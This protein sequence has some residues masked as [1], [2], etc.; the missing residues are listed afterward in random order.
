MKH[1]FGGFFG[2]S[3]FC[4]QLP[5]CLL[6]LEKLHN[7][8]E[9]WHM[10]DSTKERMNLYKCLQV[11]DVLRSLALAVVILLILLLGVACQVM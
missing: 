7:C 1:L 3:L 11:L 9:H 8:G 10:I 6:S 4:A 5:C 2:W